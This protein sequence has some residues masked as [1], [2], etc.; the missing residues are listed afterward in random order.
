MTGTRC[1]CPE[2]DHDASQ[3]CMR[4]AVWPA[5]LNLSVPE[6]VHSTPLSS[7]LEGL[8]C[9]SM[10]TV[11]V[12]GVIHDERGQGSVELRRRRADHA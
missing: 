6:H 1:R 5:D 4:D 9:G 7:S 2:R 12:V 8:V 3:G 10:V 11:V